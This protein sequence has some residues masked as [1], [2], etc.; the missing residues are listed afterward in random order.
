[1]VPV[2]SNHS[3]NNY[4]HSNIINTIIP[5]KIFDSK[6]SYES[7]VWVIAKLHASSRSLSIF[8]PQVTNLLSAQCPSHWEKEDK[9]CM[10]LPS[11]VF[12]FAPF[13][14][15]RTHTCTA[16]I[17][18]SDFKTHLLYVYAKRWD[19]THKKGPYNEV[20]SAKTMTTLVDGSDSQTWVSISHREGLWKHALLGYT[21]QSSW[22]SPENLHSRQDTDALGWGLHSENQWSRIRNVS[23]NNFTATAGKWCHSN[24]T[25]SYYMNCVQL[26]SKSSEILF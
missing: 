13:P 5:Q 11:V 12:S 15:T 8:L 4:N 24:R 26:G 21:P 25:Q 7:L 20:R 18:V 14:H 1:M 3:I 23:W 6:R 17:K 16:L 10:P 2:H 22:V 9:N 19:Q